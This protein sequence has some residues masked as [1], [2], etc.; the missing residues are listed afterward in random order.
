[1]EGEGLPDASQ[2]LEV[3]AHVARVGRGVG[4]RLRPEAR[5]HCPASVVGDRGVGQDLVP[6]VSLDPLACAS[7]TSGGGVLMTGHRVIGGLQSR[8]VLLG[9]GVAA[10]EGDQQTPLE[11]DVEVQA[12]EGLGPVVECADGLELLGAGRVAG[13]C[14]DEHTLC[15]RTG[16]SRAS[17][18]EQ[19][20]A[21]VLGGLGTVLGRNEGTYGLVDVTQGER[22]EAHVVLDGHRAQR[23]VQVIASR[24]LTVT[25]HVPR[26][27]HDDAAGQRIREL[28]DVSDREGQGLLV[29]AYLGVAEVAVVDEDEV[30]T[31][32]TRGGFDHRGGAVDVELLA[33]DLRQR[34][35]LGQR[36]AG[37][38][39]AVRAQGG[40]LGEGFLGDLEALDRAVLGRGDDG[41]QEGHTGLLQP[42]LRPRGQVAAR[43]RGQLGEQV[44]Q[45]RVGVGVLR[46]VLVQASEES[47][48]AH[49]GDE[50]AQ[51]GG[52]LGVGDAV[53][54]D[55]DVGQVADFSRDRVRRGQLILLEAPVLADHEPGPALGV[56]GGLG[57]SQVAHELGEGFVEP[58]VVPPL[59]GD[60]VTEPH[61]R[62]LVQDRVRT[63]LHLSLGGTRA[64][65]VGVAEGDAARVLHGAR[66]V[67]GHEDL[68]VLGEGVGDAVRALEE[69][70]ATARDVDDL[71]GIQVLDDR[72]AGVDAQVDRA[73]IGGCER[74]RRALIGACDDRR[75]VGRHHLGGGEA[76]DPGLA[77][78]LGG[79]GRGVGKDLPAL[80]GLD[81]QRERGLQ[82]G[83]LE[84]RVHAA[85]VRD[86]E[87]RVGIGLS[88]GR[89]DEAV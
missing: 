4:A 38:T 46:Q 26:G 39:H 23:Q 37:H 33:E 43:G 76:V 8:D 87:L 30:R 40:A 19:T 41:T 80:G 48:A 67:L 42:H 82:V 86:L 56:L 63:S 49:V 6:H 14:S 70:E 20:A 55:L 72:R 81:C 2:G 61:V 18:E 58:Q 84:R 66:V 57:Q 54:V 69:L 47:V 17:Q 22:Q 74:G 11:V 85:C 24:H 52:A 25:G 44:V 32:D 59:H 21:R 35:L 75:D 64:E 78:F 50:L 53:E 34:A 31:G 62:Q 16:G 73:A 65:H 77:L 88:V 28:G 5:D 89:V 45:R 3:L 83:L 13:C 27:G 1:M 71:V 51:Y 12:I 36:V 60:Q 79:G 29:E 7:R 10:H 68:V 9:G 15:V